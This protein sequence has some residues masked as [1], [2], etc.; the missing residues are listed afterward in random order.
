VNSKSVSPEIVPAEGCSGDFKMKMYRYAT[1]P[2]EGKVYVSG[3]GDYGRGQYWAGTREHARIYEE[4]DHRK[5]CRSG[6]VLEREIHLNNVLRMSPEQ[7]SENSKKC[8]MVRLDISVHERLAAT[9]EFT[10]EMLEAGYEGVVVHG[11]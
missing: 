9:E 10:Q 3:P 7:I 8:G 6:K 1:E 4:S 2:D 5:G 11:Y